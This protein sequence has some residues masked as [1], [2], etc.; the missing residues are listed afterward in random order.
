MLQ[1]QERSPGGG[2]GG[3][4]GGSG[5]AAHTEFACGPPLYTACRRQ[6]RALYH[7]RVSSRP[8]RLEATCSTAGT[9]QLRPVVVQPA[10]AHMT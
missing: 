8:E 7:G 6:H 5:A 2:G 9:G 1:G 10:A 4:G 3:G